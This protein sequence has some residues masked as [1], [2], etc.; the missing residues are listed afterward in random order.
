MTEKTRVIMLMIAA[1][2]FYCSCI[3]NGYEF[4]KLCSDKT[5]SYRVKK[6][7][8]LLACVNFGVAGVFMSLNACNQ[9]DEVARAQVKEV[10]ES[11]VYKLENKAVSGETQGE[12]ISDP[13]CGTAETNV[14]DLGAQGWYD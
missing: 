9:W 10:Q 2:C 1:A 3:L 7:L 14:G 12:L 8:T 4:Y 13:R 6:L 11:S 5:R